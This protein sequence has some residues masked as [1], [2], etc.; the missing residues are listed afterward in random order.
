MGHRS[1]KTFA[2]LALALVASAQGVAEPFRLVRDLAYGSR[3]DAPGEGASYVG[4]MVKDGAGHVCQTHRSGQF[5]DLL[6][7]TPSG[8][9]PADAPVF[10]WLHGGAW[11]QRWDKDGDAYHLLR[12]F[13][14]RGFV[15]VSMDY[16]LQNDVLT[17]PSVPARAQATWA[18][19][20]RDVD[21][22][23]SHLRA[24]LP[25]WGVRP[26]SFGIGGASAGA[27]LAALYA[28]DEGDPA[29]LALGLRHELPVSFAVDVV[30][31]VDLTLPSFRDPVLQVLRRARSAPDMFGRWTTL[32]ARLSGEDLASATSPVALE[33]VLRRWSP[34]AHVTSRTPPFILAYN[35]LH[36]FSSSDGLVPLACCDRMEAALSAA[37]VSCSTRVSWF[38]HHGQLRDGVQ[39]WIVETAAKVANRGTCVR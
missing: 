5:F 18:D 1:L 25:T 37:G 30:G 19:M 8:T 9:A 24:F 38:Q 23:V 20:L 2:L 31:P 11:C 15:V 35:R 14:A 10:V 13:A 7:P 32:L 36:P 22:L 27:H 12:R 39:D 34:C 6:L 21:A 28:T 29:A 16:I 33:A 17:N 26:K 3:A 4:K